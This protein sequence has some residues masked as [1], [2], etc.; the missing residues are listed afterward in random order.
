MATTKQ[1]SKHTLGPWSLCYDGQIDGANGDF[2]CSFRWSSY[3]DFNDSPQ[4]K[5]TARLIATAPEL[6]EAA[7]QATKKEGD[8]LGVLDLAIAK[9]EQNE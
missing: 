8:W 3:K 1:L 7:K 6:L 2:V 9:A 4:N 5:A